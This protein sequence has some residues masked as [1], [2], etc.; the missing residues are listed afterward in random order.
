MAEDKN[1]PE[2]PKEPEP[3]DLPQTREEFMEEVD[4]AVKRAK[5]AGLRPFQEMLKTY[6]GRLLGAVDVLLGG[7]DDGDGKKKGKKK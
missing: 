2:A 3:L 1:E 5:K 6:G 7:L 4:K